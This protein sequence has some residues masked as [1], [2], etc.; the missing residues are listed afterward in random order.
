MLRDV[1]N[2]TSALDFGVDTPAG[3]VEFLLPQQTS[4]GV[5][6]P[7]GASPARISAGGVTPEGSSPPPAPAPAPVPTPTPASAV[8][9]ATNGHANS[10]TVEVTPA[11]PRSR[12]ASLLP[13][14]VATRYGRGRKNNRATLAEL[15]E[16]G[17][18]QRL[19]GLEM[20]PPCYTEDTAHQHLQG[21]DNP[22]TSGASEGGFRQGDRESGK[23]W[24]GRAGTY[25][26]SSE[27]TKS[28]RHPLSLQDQG[29]RSKQGPT[30]R[31]AV[32]TST[33][34]RLRRHLCPCVQAPEHPDGTCDR[35]GAG[36]RG[37]HAGHANSIF[38]TLT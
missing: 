13:V 12:V 24:Y 35:R 21:G 1:Q 27:R 11:V 20:G 2:Y 10:G 28:R 18:L 3:T 25:H 36:L 8:P 26:F 7:G 14:P 22:P 38:S 16:A 34:D 37:L 6:L 5:T 17:T 4:P 29:R 23:A 9:R 15:F 30:G 32:V 19:N 33:R 31:A